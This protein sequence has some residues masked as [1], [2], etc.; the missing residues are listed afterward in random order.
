[1]TT[2]T[3]SIRYRVG[4]L[5]I[6]PSQRIVTQNGE[7]SQPRDR[8]FRLLMY[9]LQNRNRVIG[10]SELIE[11]VWEDSAISESVL[12]KTV[13]E[14]RRVVEAN[15]EAPVLI[16][17][18]PKAGYQFTGAVEEESAEP[19]VTV[20]AA[21]RGRDG[22]RVSI[23]AIAIGAMVLVLLGIGLLLYN[24]RRTGLPDEEVGW[25]RLDEN[26]GLTVR[27]SAGGNP[28]RLVAGLAG[29]LPHWTRGMM[30][31]ALAFDG[32]GGYAEGPFPF[33]LD[34]P[35][36]F[37]LWVKLRDAATKGD[38]PIFSSPAGMLLVLP[39]NYFTLRRGDMA[40]SAGTNVT[41]DNWH[42]VAFVDEGPYTHTMRLFVD[43]I[44]GSSGVSLA[45]SNKERSWRLGRFFD[46]LQSAWG[47]MDDLRAYGRP[48]RAN[49]IQTLYRCGKPEPDLTVAGSGYYYLPIFAK[50]A[51]I[52]AD[53]VIDNPSL[54]FAGVQF[55]AAGRRNCGVD[56]LRGA[57]LGQDVRIAADLLTP[58]TEGKTTESGLYFR[59]RAAYPGDGIAGG[60]SSGY[61]VKLES[62]GEVTVW[63][64][65]PYHPI[66]TAKAPGN[67]DD[68]QFHALSMEAR[69]RTLRVWLDG[70]PVAFNAAGY[71][72]ETVT[73]EATAKGRGAAGI[74]FASEANRGLAGGQKAKNVVA[75]P[76]R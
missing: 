27:D 62:S 69:G 31:N 47:L 40:L 14:L 29:V 28:G 7:T 60:T 17:T 65:N 13:L 64:L 4:R 11:Q 75:E 33:Q 61:W 57:D 54:D 46:G 18:V 50:G 37:C 42:H 24:S 1:M 45:R 73:I 59:S 36:T 72:S 49:E 15:P 26:S 8:V 66:A 38:V 22:R 6:D 55:G 76:L 74:A 53:G 52:E 5:L 25:W 63:Q 58:R 10:K 41:D 19:V 39:N 71:A 9:L 67:F 44:E 16:K 70:T 32:G 48:L 30:G 2:G 56:T 21:A 68:Q 20:P 43:G 23:W 3:P 35:S 34:A 12:Y 51:K